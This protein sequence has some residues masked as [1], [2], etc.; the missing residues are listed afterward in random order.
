ML[1]CVVLVT[2]DDKYGKYPISYLPCVCVV[3]SVV[4]DETIHLDGLYILIRVKITMQH[5]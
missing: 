2:D 1:C 5:C 4:I 3:G